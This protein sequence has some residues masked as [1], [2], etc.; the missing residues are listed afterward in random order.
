MGILETVDDCQ[1]QIWHAMFPIQGKKCPMP[2]KRDD[3]DARQA[4]HRDAV[5]N[6]QR[7]SVGDAHQR[8]IVDPAWISSL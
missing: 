1:F 8:D 5:H 4:F 6:D 3:I 7:S 2:V